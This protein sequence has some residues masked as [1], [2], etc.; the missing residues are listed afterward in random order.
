M[1]Y[2]EEIHIINIKIGK[3][4]S[5]IALIDERRT[6]DKEGSLKLADKLDKVAISVNQL[7]LTLKYKDGQVDGASKTVKFFKGLLAL[8]VFTYIISTAT[9]IIDLYARVAVLEGK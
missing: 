2:K 8:V 6:N 3:I 1:N 4:I 5:S 7:N 9:T